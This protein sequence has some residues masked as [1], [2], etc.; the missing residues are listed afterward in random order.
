[1][2]KSLYDI[3]DIEPHCSKI[4]IKSAYKKLAIKL[5]PDVNQNDKQAEAKFRIITEAYNTLSNDIK[6]RE[7]NNTFFAP[8]PTIKIKAQ[9]VKKADIF[10]IRQ[11]SY[12]QKPNVNNGIKLDIYQD[13]EISF[14][15]SIRGKKEVVNIPN[16]KSLE[17]AIPAGVVDGTYLKLKGQGKLSAD[18]KRFGDI[19]LKIHVKKH[20]HFSTDGINIYLNLEISK[21]EAILG[22]TLPI[23]T[24]SD[25]V[26]VN[27]PPNTKNGDIITLKN[28]GIKKNALTMGDQIITIRVIDAKKKLNKYSK[29]NENLYEYEKNMY[30]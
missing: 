16:H 25:I 26:K 5:H 8:K 11:Y 17:V 13:L 1:M 29:I 19:Y 15:D 9:N 10:N 2:K 4:E 14:I 30:H 28:Q 18:K 12:Y 6:R 22:R 23:Y 7:Y 24:I 21:S 3:L 27:I 20:K